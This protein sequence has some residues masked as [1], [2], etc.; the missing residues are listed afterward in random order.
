MS[1]LQKKG[2]WYYLQFFSPEKSPT[3][4][5]VSLKTRRLSAA[6][7]LQRRLEDAFSFGDYDPWVNASILLDSSLKRAPI[8]TLD[9]GISVF[10]ESKQAC[11][12]TTVDHYRWVLSS[13]A[14]VVG[15]DRL[16]MDISVSDIAEWLESGSLAAQ[17]VHTYLSRLRTFSRFLS[18]C[19]SCSS[20]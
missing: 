18:C 9:A 11:R 13:F 20:C 19:F 16:I 4:K 12:K 15:S 14:R 2:D 17:S 3:R 5:K 8:E 7:K 10:L 6:R 1:S